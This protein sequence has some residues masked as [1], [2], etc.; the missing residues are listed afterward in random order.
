[1]KGKGQGREGWTR[2]EFV[3]VGGVGLLA[4]T[5]AFGQETALRA[6]VIGHTGRGD[7]GHGMER[8]FRG[9]SGIEVVAVADPDEAGR[10]RVARFQGIAR[11]YAD[12]RDMLEKERPQLVSV[13]MR[14]ADQHAEV[15]LGCLRAG[16]HVYLEK[17][18]VRSPD[19]ADAVLAEASKRGL[20]L[21]VAHTM[22]VMPVVKRLKGAL[23]EG[24]IGELREMRAYG[25]QDARAGGEDLMVLGSHLFDL[26]RMMSGDPEWVTARVMTGGREIRVED[27]RLVKDNVGWVAGEQVFAHFGFA[28]GVNATF[29]SDSGLKEVSGHWGIEFLGSRGVARLNGDL[30]P[31]VSVRMGAGGWVPG[32]KVEWKPLDPALADSAPDPQAGPVDDWLESIRTGREPECSGRNGAW[33]VEMV[34]GI[35]R[36]SMEGRRVAFPLVDRRHPL[37]PA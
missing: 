5:N 3:A 6:A 19:E 32:K 12:W 9:R 37:G 14:H 27:R 15:A 2:R 31:R 23:A 25:K 22:R 28:N 35:Y 1:M 7:Y 4:S 16:A 20:K 24:L 18:F 8:V 29:T 10:G 11:G 17:P 30:V 21:A 33:T 13:G 36:A 34:L 26:M